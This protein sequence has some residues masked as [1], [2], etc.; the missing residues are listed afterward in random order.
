MNK[1]IKIILSILVGVILLGLIIFASVY[2]Y[3]DYHLKKEGVRVSLNDYALMVDDCDTEDAA[4]C[5]K[6][7]SINDEDVKLVFEYIDFE[8]DGYPKTLVGTINGHEFFNISDMDFNSNTYYEIFSNFEVI[9]D[10]IVFTY[11]DGASYNGLSTTLYAVDSE[12]NVALE[13]NEIDDMYIKDYESDY[14]T[15]NDNEIVVHTT[16]LNYY[17]YVGDDSICDISSKKI[18][19]AY[20]TYTYKDGK[21]TKKV[22]DTLTAKEYIAN[23]D[24]ECDS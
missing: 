12:G 7:I 19:D 22:G 5:V 18:V 17:N 4:T 14:L 20:Y 11:T 13:E 9:G 3:K 23:N 16:L 24:I 6:N 2:P 8:E 15:Y 1:K 10:Y 21:F